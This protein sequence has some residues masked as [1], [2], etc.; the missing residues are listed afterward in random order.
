MAG[1]TD[2]L[3]RG[4]IKTDPL[5]DVQPGFQM[6]CE[7]LAFPATKLHLPEYDDWTTFRGVLAW[8]V[9]GTPTVP[10]VHG[11]AVLVAP[12]V[13]IAAK[14]VFEQELPDI[15]AGVSGCLCISHVPWGMDIWRV[16]QVCSIELTDLVV[17]LLER[18]SDLP[19]GD[20]IHYAFLSTRVPAVG[21]LVAM[22]GYVAAAPSFDGKP[23]AGVVHLAQG[24]VA[25][26][27]IDGRDRVL[28]PGPCLEVAVGAK[29]GMSGGPVFDEAGA[30]IGIVSSSNGD[31]PND[32][33]FVS[34]ALPAL[35]R[36]IHP[37]WPKGL[38]KAETSL[39]EFGS[40]LNS[41]EQAD[42]IVASVTGRF[43]Y[44][45]KSSI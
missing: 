16:H 44:V 7:A 5:A 21:E 39:L 17:L 18:Q 14:H 22:V 42:G 26:R 43:G 28:L 24:L 11:S 35:V 45:F 34:L 27:Y 29:G 3:V 12:G 10:R 38:H 25:N 20:R 32:Y 30:L 8:I 23:I 41:V 2:G 36:A 15:M 6:Q 13:A 9:T 4:Q 33:S 19:P 37:C 31:G 40:S 1:M